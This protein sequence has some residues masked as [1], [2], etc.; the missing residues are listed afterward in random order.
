MELFPPFGSWT[1]EDPISKKDP[2]SVIEGPG[3]SDIS[4]DERRRIADEARRQAIADAVANPSNLG[5]ALEFLG[6]EYLGPGTALEEKLKRGVKPIDWMDAAALQHDIAYRDAQELYRAG[7]VSFA[8]AKD[9]ISLADWQLADKLQRTWDPRGQFA[10]AG[11]QW[12]ML[13]DYVTGSSSFSGLS[14]ITPPGHPGDTDPWRGGENVNDSEYRYLHD[15][16]FPPPWGGPWK[17]TG[18]QYNGVWE[19]VESSDPFDQ[20]AGPIDRWPSVTEVTGFIEDRNRNGIDDRLEKQR[21]KKNR[22]YFPYSR[23]I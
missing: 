20:E 13:Y 19:P 9:L 14:D 21:K 2:P 3:S 17:W 10:S 12:K 22:R 11:M 23:Y 8:E 15:P 6:Y 4:E 18:G 16:T 5:K 7:E 1:P